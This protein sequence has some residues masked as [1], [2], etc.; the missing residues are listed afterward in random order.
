MVK[1]HYSAIEAGLR[2]RK[3]RSHCETDSTSGDN[4]LDNEQNINGKTC[5]YMGHSS[6]VTVGEDDLLRMP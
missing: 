1:P 3:G 5:R 4:W 6:F 2:K